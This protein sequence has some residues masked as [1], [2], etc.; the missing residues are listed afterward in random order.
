MTAKSMAGSSILDAASAAMD[1]R[2]LA[3]L[4]MMF[5]SATIFGKLSTKTLGSTPKLL[6]CSYRWLASI[7]KTHPVSRLVLVERFT[8][9]VA[10]VS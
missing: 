4:K 3:K 7:A 5:H 10:V 2:S 9:E 8:R 1:A 6:E